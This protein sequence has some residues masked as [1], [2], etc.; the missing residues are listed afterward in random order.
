MSHFTSHPEPNTVILAAELAEHFQKLLSYQNRSHTPYSIV[1]SGANLNATIQVGKAYIEGYEVGEAGDSD[2]AEVLTAAATNHIY[3]QQDGSV[4]VNTSGTPPA[5]SYKLFEVTTNGTGTTGVTDVQSDTIEFDDPLVVQ[6]LESLGFLKAIHLNLVKV[7]P[8]IRMEDTSGN[9]RRLW[10]RSNQLQV[11]DDSG[12]TVYTT[13]LAAISNPVNE[14]DTNAT[15][16]KT[17]SNLL[18]KG[19]QDTKTVVDAATASATVN[20]L[21]KRDAAGRFKAAA[22]AAAGDVVIKSQLDTVSGDLS[23]HIADAGD[24]HAAAAYILADGTRAFAAAQSMG[25]FRLTNV[26]APSTGSD[27]ARKTEVDAVQTNLTTHQNLESAPVH[28]STSAATASKLVHRD[29]AGR[30]KFAAAAAAGDAL[31][32]GQ[33][34]GGDLTGTYPNPTLAGNT[35]DTAELVNLAVTTAKVAN[36]AIDNTKLADMAQATIKGRA[37]GA[38]TGDPVD[39][40]ATQ[41]LDI[42]KT[43]DGAGSGLDADTVDGYNPATGTGA[44]TLA[45]RDSNGRVQVAAPSFTAD[46]DAANVKAVKQVGLMQGLFLGGM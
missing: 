24:P 43:V 9:I 11:T 29:A 28:G 27:A 19:W 12:S 5:N 40:T 18:A 15:K 8:Y 7:Q 2:H 36:G 31:I 10:L 20:T 34:A 21:V 41:V 14:A 1:T 25:G 6:T 39:L 3:L 45:R 38:G 35:V 32:H 13:D 22:G 42:I 30:A 4:V 46:T 44:N 17:V 23:T 26:A 37:D 33:T 16:D